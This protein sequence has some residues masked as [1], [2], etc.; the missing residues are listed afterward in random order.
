[1]KKLLTL[2]LITISTFSFAQY[3]KLDASFYSES[4]DEIKNIDIFLPADYYSNL[5]QEYAVIYYL[6][7]A[8]G[9]QNTGTTNALVYYNTHSN[10]TNI[11]SPAAIFVC[12]D[13]S[14]EPYLGSGYRN[15][16][17]Y[18]DYDD[19][20]TSDVI[21]F[22]ENNFR[23]NSSRDFRFIC[24]T[25][26][27]G[28]GTGWHATDKPELYRAAFPY[29]GFLGGDEIGFINVWRDLVYDENGSYTNISPGAGTN[30]KLF[31]TMAGAVSPNMNMPNY[32]EIPW[33]SLGNPVDSV[34]AKWANSAASMVGNIP[35]NSN[36]TFF[37]GCGTQ[38][39]MGTY[40]GYLNFMDSLDAYNIPYEYDYF[41]GGH[42]YNAETWIKGFLWMDSIINQ[43][44]QHQGFTINDKLKD[45]FIIYPNPAIKELNIQSK[46]FFFAR[47]AN[48]V[49]YNL[50]GRMIESFTMP[51]TGGNI[52]FKL[53]VS[54]YNTGL[55]LLHIVTDSHTYTKKFQVK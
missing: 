8:G 44:F 32:V 19:Y 28:Y 16:I 54:E 7:G 20:I 5:E 46:D 43:S 41:E 35:D 23:A 29:I 25:S 37:L 52:N 51:V 3:I 12:P 31:L 2:F 4:L 21:N 30:T 6:H 53:N 42:E 49:V 13:G 48:C 9:D 24:G 50:E 40:P 45:Q 47:N 10:N 33:D 1:M 55:F 39:Y 14:C 22:I 34:L 11:N 17:L 15:S 18:G 38:D 26:M 36:L 27:G